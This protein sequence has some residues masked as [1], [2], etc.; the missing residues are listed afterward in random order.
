MGCQNPGRKTN[1]DVKQ[2]TVDDGDKLPYINWFAGFLNHQQ[3][4]VA[5]YGKFLQHICVVF[6]LKTQTPVKV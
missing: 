5:Y 4:V 1:W 6:S 2:E 3:D